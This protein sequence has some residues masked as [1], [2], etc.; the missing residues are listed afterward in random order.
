MLIPAT[1]GAQTTFYWA[2]SAG[3]PTTGGSGNWNTS[4][5]WSSTTPS[6][7][8]ASWSG[9]T[10][11]AVFDG[12]TSGTIAVGTTITGNTLTFNR[13]YI[14]DTQGN[15]LT[16]SSLTLNNTGTALTLSGG[17][18]VTSGL[19]VSASGSN[20]VALGSSTLR[21]GSA[22]N[23]TFAGVISGAGALVKL[24]SGDQVLSGAN[25]Y[26]GGTTVDAGKLTIS[27]ASA[28]GSG[29][30]E[31]K[32]GTTLGLLNS[33]ANN[34]KFTSGQVTIDPAALLT[35]ARALTG[36]L[37]GDATLHFSG[38]ATNSIT[39]S[40]S[41][42]YTGGTK[43]TNVRLIV[44]AD[45]AFGATNSGIQLEN[46][47]VLSW[48]SSFDLN[49]SRSISLSLITKLA[50]NGFSTTIAQPI[51]GTGSLVMETPGTLTL[52]GVN[53]FSG[54]LVVGTGTVVA[55]GNAALGASGAA[56]DIGNGGLLR[57]SQTTTLPA[58]RTLK[59][60]TGGAATISADAGAT[61][62]VTAALGNSSGGTSNFTKAGDG[63]LV[64]SAAP[65]HG[66]T[67]TVSGGV[68]RLGTGPDPLATGSTVTVQS[69]AELDF[70]GNNQTLLSL[71]G[72]GNVRPDGGTLSIGSLTAFTGRFV[73]AGTVRK[74]SGGTYTLTGTGEAFTGTFQLEAGTLALLGT[75]GSGST[76]QMSSGTTLAG[77]GTAGT[78]Q[79]VEGATLAP[80][81]SPGALS[82]G[83]TTLAGGATYTWE[84]NNATGGA[85]TGW[86]VLQV[87]GTLTLTAT[88]GNRLNIDVVSLDLGNA[89]GSAANFN[90][91]QDY[92]FPLITTT[93][94]ITGFD[95]AAIDLDLGAFANSFT[96][97]FAVAVSGNNLVLTYYTATYDAWSATEFSPAELLNP[98]ISG[99][100]ADPDL[101]GLPNL[102]EFAL[103]KGP[104]AVNTTG[105][106][107]VSVIATNWAYT[108]TRPTDRDGITYTV[109]K[110][111]DLVNWNTTSV[112][113]ALVSSAA[114]VDTWRATVPLATAPNCYFRLKV[115]NQ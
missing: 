114:G 17:G 22:S 19:L 16:F 105:V 25:T 84:I 41:N 63:T 103:G 54:G 49:S 83:D 51:T 11:H 92:V 34:I 57:F 108:Y 47:S 80:G 62:T 35:P 24:G 37:S 67:T 14:L 33:V 18:T 45:A 31:F 59:L 71:V 97:Q 64:L 96:G 79:V 104:K 112:T 38:T 56:V 82:A 87:T 75:L 28:L 85:G 100:N 111:T 39:L 93:G 36:V 44:G 88:A 46:G 66:G 101:D 98:S 3:N 6:Y 10:N 21:V 52:N 72:A 9:T 58:N 8:S 60:P 20:S 73:G 42:T 15:T 110:S 70:D 102:V 23:G 95:E 1:L 55:N 40:G 13:S 68:L 69:G 29:S 32:A 91:A 27:N 43:V 77:T 61:V 65:T 50:L 109:E 94:G 99:P 76:L 30:A 81:T 7:T 48:A 90:P 115:T 86:D 4:G 12:D 113:H 106:P 5:H 26:S 74:T 2:G 107:E 89:P 53:T 78:V